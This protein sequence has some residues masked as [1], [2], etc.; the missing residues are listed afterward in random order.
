MKRI[1]H[2]SMWIVVLIVAA[3]AVAHADPILSLTLTPG[4][5]LS[6]AA[7]STIGWGYTLSNTENMYA[8]ITGADFCGAVIT[9]PC[10]TP[11]GAFTDF[12]A[13]FNFTVIDPFSTVT[14]AF[15][16]DSFSGIGSYLVDAGALPGD[17][18][19]GQITLTY[20]FYSD[21][22]GV[23]LVSADNRVSTTAS[24][25]VTADS[26]S[27]TPLPLPGT[28]MLMSSALAVFVIHR[29]KV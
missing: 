18:F 22:P 19:L 9:S 26:G 17:S 13:Q 2:N 11:L 8:V 3:A 20:D 4:G 21:A 12:I 1:M 28:L 25:L 10:S 5:A 14:S 15:D 6:G 29:M 24:I 23:G 7:G 27:P 16:P